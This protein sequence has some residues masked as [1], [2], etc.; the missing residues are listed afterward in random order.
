VVVQEKKEKVSFSPV[1]E[2]YREEVEGA[3]K[4]KIETMGGNTLLRD[5][6]EYALL[7]G[8]KR[9]RPIVVLMMGRALGKG[10]AVFEAAMAIEFFHTASLVA[11]D[12]PSMDDDD[13]RRCKP[14]LHKK[15][16][17]ALAL[18]TSYGLIAEGYGCIAKNAKDEEGNVCLLALENA[19][20]NTGLL[21]ATGGQF[22]DV[23]PPNFS[24]ETLKEV[25]SKKTTALFEV[26]FVFGWLFGGG[27][28]EALGEVKRAAEHFGLAFQLADDI[29]DFEQ[30]LLKEK[31]VNYAVAF[32]KE[33]ALHL[34]H[35]EMRLF[36]ETLL[37]L[38][39]AMDEWR[40]LAKFIYPSC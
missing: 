35:E 17:E 38:N 33:A 3:I 26:A 14:S 10:K 21:G 30:D 22:L 8:G 12:L 5:A 20:Y 7:N 11:D 19:T 29:D 28:A 4:K 2:R 6:C 9:L 37:R 40:E 27:D 1:L 39:I 36:D 32:G 13:E 16:N 15:Y 34:F 18:L 25:I 24:E 23:F 31:R